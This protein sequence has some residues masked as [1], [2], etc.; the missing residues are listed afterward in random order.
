MHI[1]S[2]CLILVSSISLKNVSPLNNWFQGSPVD[3]DQFEKQ[4][5][6][7]NTLLNIDLNL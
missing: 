2:F 1:D 4:Y 6:R 7:N 3:F 5:F